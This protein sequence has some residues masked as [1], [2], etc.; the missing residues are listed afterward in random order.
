MSKEFEEENTDSVSVDSSDDE[1]A[2]EDGN[3]KKDDDWDTDF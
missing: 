1:E 3:E 2:E